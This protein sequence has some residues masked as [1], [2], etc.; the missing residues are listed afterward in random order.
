VLGALTRSMRSYLRKCV[1]K[2]FSLSGQG[3]ILG[4]AENVTRIKWDTFIRERTDEAKALAAK[5]KCKDVLFEL[6]RAV[7]AFND[8]VSPVHV[9]KDG[10]PKMFFWGQL[11]IA[12]STARALKEV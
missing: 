11:G 4:R 2:L 8:S 5:G 9:T 12:Q 7:H 1:T 3:L 6:G 10:M